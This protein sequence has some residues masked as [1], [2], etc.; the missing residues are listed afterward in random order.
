MTATKDDIVKALAK[1]NGFQ[2]NRAVEIVEILLEKVPRIAI[3]VAE[4]QRGITLL[5]R[6]YS[7]R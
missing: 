6:N 4:T 2:K 1:E 3:S 7:R 5:N